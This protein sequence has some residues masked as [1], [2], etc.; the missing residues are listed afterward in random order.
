MKKLMN[1]M[2][3]TIMVMSMG[4]SASAA[5]NTDVEDY[6]PVIGNFKY[7]PQVAQKIHHKEMLADKYYN[8]KVSGNIEEM[9]NY[10]MQLAPVDKSTHSLKSTSSTSSRL[11]IYQVAQEKNYWCGYAAIK[12]LL[13]FEGVSKTQT[14]IAQEVYKT[15]NSCPWYLSNG[16]SRDQ[17]PVPNYLEDKIG[18]YYIPY[19]YG[20]AGTTNV[21]ASNIKPKVVATIDA[22]HGLMACG[23]SYGNISGH[24]SILPNYPAKEIGHWLAIDGYKDS[25][26]D[27]WIVD[28]AKSDAV[29]WGDNISKYYSITTDKLAAFVKARGLVW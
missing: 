12:S 29:S 3:V 22:G 28:P 6:A 10:K 25:G 16:D 4:L 21:Q 23:R 9:K 17:F 19:P 27:T 14:T 7:D 20:A 8:A 1:L 2:L 11:S 15:S 13:D 5:I 26:D 24:A 18:F